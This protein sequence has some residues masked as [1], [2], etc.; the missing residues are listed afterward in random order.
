MA[1]KKVNT[2]ELEGSYV[3]PRDMEIAGISK[4]Y[5]EMLEFT[6]NTYKKFVLDAGEVA[7]V[8][9]AGVQL[10]VQFLTVL[11]SKGCE[12]SWTN[13]SI[14]IYQ[15]AAELGVAEQLEE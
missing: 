2:Q 15:M 5:Q 14:Q 3:L 6:Q 7:L 11:R 9:T 4:V 8:D 13:D 10:I 1:K 12:I